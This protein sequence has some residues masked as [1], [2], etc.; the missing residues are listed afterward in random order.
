MQKEENLKKLS[1][2]AFREMFKDG[3]EKVSGSKVQLIG[4]LCKK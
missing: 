1:I 3:D 2:S 4:R